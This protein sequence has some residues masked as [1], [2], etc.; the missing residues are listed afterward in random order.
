MTEA[1]EPVP[2]DNGSHG[3]PR[4]AAGAAPAAVFD[5]MTRLR[6]G[7]PIHPRGIVAQAVVKRTGSTCGRWGIPWLD[8]PG[9]DVGI[10]RFSRAAGLPA[11]V[12]DVLGLAFTAQGARHAA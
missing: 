9:T 6:H 4:V 10:V 5:V 11:P 3:A 7:K 1:V 2:V 8:E 12:P